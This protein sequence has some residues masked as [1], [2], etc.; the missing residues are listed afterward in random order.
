MKENS[1]VFKMPFVGLPVQPASTSKI[2]GV[3]CGYRVEEIEDK[4]MQKS[5]TWINR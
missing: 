5:D 4:L 2:T 3:K 1:R